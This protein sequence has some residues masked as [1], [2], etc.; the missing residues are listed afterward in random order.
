MGFNTTILVILSWACPKTRLEA[1][2]HCKS[3]DELLKRH[4]RHIHT[5]LVK[6]NCMTEVPDIVVRLRKGQP[7][8]DD[9]HRTDGI[10]IHSLNQGSH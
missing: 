6:R 4:L 2:D 3:D 1:P 8:R 5:M 10:P 7:F 9:S